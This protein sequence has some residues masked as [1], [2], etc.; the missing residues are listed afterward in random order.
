M[1]LLTVMGLY[2]YDNTL[3]DTMVYP[4]GMDGDQLKNNIILE[5]AEL[6]V[7]YPEPRF[8]K[9][10]INLWSHSRI[11][12]WNRIYAASQLEYNPIE[13]YNRYETESTGNT[14]QHTGSDTTS[15]TSQLSGSDSTTTSTEREGSNTATNTK[16]YTGTDTTSATSQ[17]LAK[18][19]QLT[20]KSAKQSPGRMLQLLAR[21]M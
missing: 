9:T 3:L 14:R 20:E 10:A 19:Q 7:I 5:T 18:Q 13:N 11:D 6:E 2:N 4:S 15:T 16:K 8:F 21:I 12:T 1:A 17:L